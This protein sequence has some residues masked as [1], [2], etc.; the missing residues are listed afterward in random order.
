[1]FTVDEWYQKNQWLADTYTAPISVLDVQVNGSASNPVVS[2]M[3]YRGFT[4]G[5][6][7]TRN[8]FFLIEDGLWKHRFGQEEIDQFLPGASYEEFVAAQ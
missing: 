4:D 7:Q 3:V 8:T 6:S 1:M 5:T 2:V